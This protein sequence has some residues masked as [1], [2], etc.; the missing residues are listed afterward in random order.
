MKWTIRQLKD[1]PDDIIN[2][3]ESLDIKEQL[4][5]RNPS[6]LD[7]ESVNVNGYFVPSNE[8][9]IL[10]G[11]I[12]TRLTVPSSRSLEPVSLHLNI[13][14]SERYVYE[15]YDG[16]V[17]EYEETTIVLQYDYIDL[18]AAVTDNIAIN[19]PTRVLKPGEEDGDLPSG[20]DWTVVT[21]EEYE[22]NLAE[23][24]AET[25]DPRFAALK[26]LLDN[27]DEEQ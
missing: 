6:I 5:E 12:D 20:N 4:M 18:D 27:E 3:E 22:Q 19:I 24:K 9:I 11:Q 13:P 2:F 16:N 17:G 7:V 25:V 14:I 10:H 21:E 23:E 8:D 1:H 26:T 15:E